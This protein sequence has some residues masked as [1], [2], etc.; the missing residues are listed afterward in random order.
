MSLSTHRHWKWLFWVFF[1]HIFYAKAEEMMSSY[2]SMRALD[3]FGTSVQLMHAREAA[4]RYGRLVVAARCHPL[5]VSDAAS[6]VV[7]SV[8]NHKMV[9]SITL[10]LSADRQT[11]DKK[12]NKGTNSGFV[13]ICCTGVKSDA[14][15]LIRY[16]QRYAANVWERYDHHPMGTSALA[17]SI[18]R[19]LGSYQDDDLEEE[20][21]SAI[22][23]QNKKNAQDQLESPLSRPLGVQ[24]LLLSTDSGRDE[25]NLLLVEPT[26]RVFKAETTEFF[27]F[28]TMGKQSDILNE[29]LLRS[30]LK[31]PSELEK[32]L[33]R[34]ILETLSPSRNEVTELLVETIGPSSGIDT[35]LLVC[36][37]GQVKSRSALTSTSI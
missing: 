12:D 10:P 21:Q 19:L 8:G 37:N 30:T 25:P 34:E 15:W 35:V 1:H 14:D 24:T 16:M 18:S 5:S 3:K 23:R 9:R 32:L 31:T 28:V 2:T 20:W 29:R 13:A 4:A 11:S 6:V 27:S 7:V 26:G 36:K 17:H 33:I 22:G